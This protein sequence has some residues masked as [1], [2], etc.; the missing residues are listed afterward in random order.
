[1]QELEE[2]DHQCDTARDRELEATRTRA[3]W[4]IHEVPAGDALRGRMRWQCA[5]VSDAY[6]LLGRRLRGMGRWLRSGLSGVSVVRRLVER[7]RVFFTLRPPPGLRI[8]HAV[9]HHNT[10]TV[11]V[12]NVRH[13]AVRV[14]SAHVWRD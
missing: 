8:T 7:G 1:P 9:D 3:P 2:D 12:L 13:R 14:M 4:K 11:H 6:P 5:R 10:S